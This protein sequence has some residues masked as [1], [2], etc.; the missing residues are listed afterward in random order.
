MGFLKLVF[1]LL[2]EK[3]TDLLKGLGKILMTVIFFKFTVEI[4]SQFL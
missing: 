1:F 2:I 3:K 4:F